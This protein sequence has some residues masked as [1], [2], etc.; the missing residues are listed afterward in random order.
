[1]ANDFFDHQRVADEQLVRDADD[2]DPTFAQREQPFILA[3]AS[4]AS[5]N[6]AQ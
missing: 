4:I 1:V 2:L 5:F 3:S 6:S